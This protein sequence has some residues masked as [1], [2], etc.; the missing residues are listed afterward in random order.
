M[1]GVGTMRVGFDTGGTFTDIVIL[2]P[3]GRIRTRKVLSDLDLIADAIVA[4]IGSDTHSVEVFVHGTT[5]AAN[6]VIEGNTALTGLI[7]TLGF[8]DDLE[9]RQL[10][11]PDIY[12]LDWDRAP[13][14]VPRHLRLEVAER[15]LASGVVDT[16]L[17][18][19]QVE[20]A[21]TNLVRKG[22]EVIAVS[23]I[24]SYA[25][26]AHEELVR[27]IAGRVAPEMTVCLS[28]E[29]HPEI[30]EYERTST[31]VVNASL[32]PV[33]D[34]YLSRLETRLAG[35]SSRFLVMQSNGGVM[36]ARRA[37][38][39]PCLI[40]ESG[41]AAGALAA[42]R[43][44]KQLQLPKILSF[45]VGGTTAKACLVENYQPL[46]KPGGEIGGGANLASRSF[47]GAGHA[48]WVPSID[49]AEVGAGG[50]SIA[51]LDADNILRVGPRSAGANPGPACYGR[52]GTQ[53]TVTDAFVAL[54][55][56]S[57]AGM[58]EGSLPLD[59]DAA[60]AALQQLADPLGR[61]VDEL[62]F[63]VIQVATSVMSRAVRAVS[64]DRGQD[65]REFTMVA[66]GGAGPMLGAF[67][68]E[69]IG[70]TKVIIPMRPGLF[71]A[72]GLLMAD[73]RLDHILSTAGILA[74]QSNARLR[75][76]IERM[77]AEAA[78]DMAEQGVR[79]DDV[80]FDVFADLKYGYQVSELTIPC[81]SSPGVDLVSELAQRFHAAHLS[82]FGYAQE[83]EPVSLVNLRLRATAASGGLRFDDLARVG[84]AAAPAV[85]QSAYFGRQGRC[86]T[87]VMAR[88]AFR[89][90]ES[91][92]IIVQ[93][94]DTTIVVPPGWSARL[95]DLNNL[96]LSVDAGA[97][98]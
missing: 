48:V 43:L 84:A 71:S 54:G 33:V 92:P 16:P 5:Q 87:R 24:N 70:L 62:A 80:H 86:T 72:L 37:R 75:A 44:A 49:L 89:G 88:A 2:E 58:A 76:E 23:F 30:R 41:P 40:I 42:A 93:E 7:T 81:D 31:T 11:R 95:D 17:D 8:R 39:L 60:L 83:H 55:Y 91:G 22:V 94:P 9:I 6:A 82:T 57:P 67:L 50:G 56:V 32:M 28:S 97:S 98:P 20:G 51:W 35:L 77:K 38:E 66:F 63:A 73:Y 53:P 96:H 46:E 18:E 3:G 1:S 52:G 29:V 59:R 65:P 78:H 47:S 25:N 61:S 13:A 36:S 12:D 27:R 64:S 79:S 15:V 45:D 4:F 26:P 74:A 19:R 10:K 90:V 34:R 14:L 85:T 21:I 68:A 69:S